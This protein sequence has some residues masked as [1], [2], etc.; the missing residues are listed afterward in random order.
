MT[1]SI[2]G[3]A[4]GPSPAGDGTRVATAGGLLVPAGSETATAVGAVGAGSSAAGWLGALICC[5]TVAADAEACGRR[6]SDKDFGGT[7][8]TF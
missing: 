4:D 8:D 5:N 7:A 3:M 6:D 1:L 2:L